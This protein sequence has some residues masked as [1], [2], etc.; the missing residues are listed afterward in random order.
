M[1]EKIQK[2]ELER[3]K[4][5][6]PSLYKARKAALEGQDRIN[7]IVSSFRQ[8]KS[9]LQEAQRHL[10]PLV[11]E[12]LQQELRTLDERIARLEKT[13]DSLRKAKRNPDLLVKK[14]VGELL[15]QSAPSTLELDGGP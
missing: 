14:R 2:D 5:E 6:N 10:Y 4:K 3:L 9:S 8:G 7:E 1:M 12:Q 13:L 15:G 11:K